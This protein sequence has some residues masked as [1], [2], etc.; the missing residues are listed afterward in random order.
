MIESDRQPLILHGSPVEYVADF[1][2]LGSLIH[3]DGRSGYD[4]HTCIATAAMAFGMLKKSIFDDSWLTLHMKRVLYNAC[5]LALLLYGSGCWTPFCA[6]VQ[7]VLSFH[8]HHVQ[9]ILGLSRKDT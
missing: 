1:R 6:D 3:C 2:Y 8:H 5:V 4:V 7:A 9:S